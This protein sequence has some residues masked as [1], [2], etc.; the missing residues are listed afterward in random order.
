MPL[1]EAQRQDVCACTRARIAEAECLFGCS[2]PPVPVRFDLHGA[3]AGQFRVRRAGWR[4]DYAIRY[5]PW[6]FAA[7]FAHHRL[8][9]VGHEVAHYIVYLL[10]PRARPHGS[11][12]KDLMRH[13]GATPR[14]RSPYDLT[15]VPLRRQQRHPYHCA[16]PDLLHPLSTT[17]HRRIQQGTR[18]LC[19]RCGTPLHHEHE[20]SA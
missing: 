10:H 19:R 16:C 5:N 9:T 4:R 17:R 1:S 7:D 2:F 8:D 20:S 13:F 18:Y 3:S 11:E 12:W 6:V 15:G 14:A